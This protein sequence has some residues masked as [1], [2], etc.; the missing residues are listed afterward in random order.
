MV[1]I[2]FEGSLMKLNRYLALA[3]SVAALAIIAAILA[4]HE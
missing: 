3:W 1:R 4:F 2:F